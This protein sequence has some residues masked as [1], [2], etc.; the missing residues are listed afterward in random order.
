M[1]KTSDHYYEPKKPYACADVSSFE[2]HAGILQKMK[3]MIDGNR[4]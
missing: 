4:A 3:G 2:A 1:E